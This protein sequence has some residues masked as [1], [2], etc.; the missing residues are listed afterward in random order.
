MKKRPASTES[1]AN[2]IN[3][4]QQTIRN[5]EQL[6]HNV[7]EA[8]AVLKATHDS[9]KSSLH[10][11]RLTFEIL[12]GGTAGMHECTIG[13][14]RI[15]Q[16]QNVYEKRYHMQTINLNQ[17]EWCKYLLGKN[18]TGVFA[19]FCKLFSECTNNETLAYIHDIRDS[20]RSL[21][22]KC[23]S[24]LRNITAHY[25]NPLNIYQELILLNSEDE[26]V[27]RL[28]DQMEIYDKIILL[29]KSIINTI[30]SRIP[31]EKAISSHKPV[32]EIDLQ[33]LINNQIANVLHKTELQ[34]TI[35]EQL[36]TAWDE[37]EHLRKNYHMCQKMIEFFQ[38]QNIDPSLAQNMLS[39]LDFQWAVTFMRLDLTCAMS[40]YLNASTI[41]DRSVCLRRIYMIETAALTHLYGYEEEYRP[42]SIWYKIKKIAEFTSIPE[43][44][45]I[46][47]RLS[48]HTSILNCDKRNM[49]THYWENGSSNISKRWQYFQKMDHFKELYR[50]QDLIL[51]CKDIYS[52]T[53]SLLLE[54]NKSQNKRSA[55]TTKQINEMICKIKDMGIKCNNQD[56]INSAEKLH[57]ILYTFKLK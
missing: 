29:V 17:F 6:L 19:Q 52:Y 36:S 37:I 56:I 55:E 22:V 54:M 53:A 41:L 8:K 48:E 35:N 16:T 43:S 38:Q 31:T 27:Q 46:E 15:L 25:D 42:K 40:S 13:L 33:T 28:S 44:A 23:N 10:L 47:H 34:K 7:E 49:Y 18:E 26:Y 4:S 51:L 20:I 1:I 57:A 2:L 24:K 11:L 30:Q 3:N 5:C 9:N 12:S 14:C 39:L 32:T 50:L 45:Q 21:G